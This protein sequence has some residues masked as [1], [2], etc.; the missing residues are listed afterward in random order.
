MKY[1]Q[2]EEFIKQFSKEAWLKERKRLYD[3]KYRQANKEKRR[4]QD[5]IYWS[6]HIEEKRKYNRDYESNR[7]KADIQFKLRK[8][9]RGRINK[10]IK[11]QY[12]SEYLEDILGISIQKYKE[13]LENLFTEEMSWDN[14]GEVWQIDH[15]IP[16]RAFDLTD[17]EQL[18]ECFNYKNT[19][20]LL[21]EE[22]L[23]KSDK[24]PDGILARNL[25]NPIL[26][27]S[28]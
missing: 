19:Q 6:K 26:K 25:K 21:K 4:E 3:I 20:P 9:I 7:K 14:Y 22:N 28:V 2:K 13:Y 8:S 1:P 15:I 24:L 16:C 17:E 23:S 27:N 5:K 18:K 12:N 11:L 10:L